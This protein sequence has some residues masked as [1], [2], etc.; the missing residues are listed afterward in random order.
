[1]KGLLMKVPPFG[2]P[3]QIAKEARMAFLVRIADYWLLTTDYWLLTTDYKEFLFVLIISLAN[4]MCL[5]I[6]L[7]PPSCLNILQ[8]FT[9]SA[10]WADS[11]SK[12]RCPSVYLCHFFLHFFNVLLLPFTNVA[13]RISQL[14]KDSLGNNYKWTLVSDLTILAQKWPKIAAWKKVLFGLCHS[15]F[16]D[17]GQD[18]HQ[19][20]TVHSGGVSRERVRG[21]GCWR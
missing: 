16:M 9:E 6:L 5:C 4:L 17:L 11:V 18:Q 1:M 19:H 15:L 14:Q 20:P 13:G 3:T 10:H 7:F 2:F 8:I 21:C 12:W